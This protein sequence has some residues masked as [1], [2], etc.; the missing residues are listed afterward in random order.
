[1]SSSL[2]FQ[3]NQ[4]YLNTQNINTDNLN[5]QN[6]SS[7]IN[8][9]YN[10]LDSSQQL[11]VTGTAMIVVGQSLEKVAS[12]SMVQNGIDAHAE[13]LGGQQGEMFEMSANMELCTLDSLGSQL[14]N[15]GSMLKTD[16]A[17]H[18]VQ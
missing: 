2:D 17:G 3:I 5:A 7:T 14:C 12:S 9:Q 8:Q 13:Q 18:S 16:A 10:S 15:Q 4:Q 1:M 6:L 11:N